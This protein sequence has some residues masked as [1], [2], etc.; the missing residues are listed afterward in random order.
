MKIVIISTVRNEEDIVEAF[1]RYHLQFADH[2]MI[3]NHRSIDASAEIL[4]RLK[5]EGLSLEI[6][7]ETSLDLQQGV[8]LTK[9]MKKAVREHDADWVIPLDADEFLAPAEDGDIV[10]ILASLPDDRVVKVPWRTYVPLSTDDDREIDAFKRIRSCKKSESIDLRKIMI[11]R[12]LASHA[13]GFIDN[14]NHGFMRKLL[15]KKK[16]Y[17]Y[18]N[19]NQLVLAHYPIRSAHQI[20]IKA[21]IGW[22]ACCAKPNKLPTEN[23]HLKML[24]DRFSKGST[25]SW[26]DLTRLSM[27]YATK[28]GMAIPKETDIIYKPIAGAAENV[29]LRYSDKKETID[30][31]ALLATLAEEFAEALAVNRSSSLKKK[32]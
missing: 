24:Y 32:Y 12:M 22:L 21:F 4:N 2:M 10:S 16:Q 31:L 20:M 9:L 6:F 11:S 29:M 26:E 15:W 25:L 7:E 3:I 17:P 18:V 5:E 8:F 13:N 27:G 30:P 14:G 28:E 23:Y 1:V 19:T